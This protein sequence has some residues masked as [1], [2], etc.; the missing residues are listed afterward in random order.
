MELRAV[1]DL[2]RDRQHKED[3][4]S[5]V[6]HD[7]HGLLHLG[8]CYEYTQSH[9]GQVKVKKVTYYTVNLQK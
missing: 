8:L 1:L 3:V 9:T 6:I 4:S 5:L 2:R 7:P